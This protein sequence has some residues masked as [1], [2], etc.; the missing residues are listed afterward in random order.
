MN[1]K[2]VII[3]AAVVAL[4]A[5]ISTRHLSLTTST[6]SPLPEFSLPD[7]A[8][9]SHNI[10]EWHGKIL[11]INFWATWCPPCLKEIPEFISLQQTYA[12]KNLT[13]IGIAMD[14]REA[15]SQFIANKPVNYPILMTKEDGIA[16]TRKLGNLADAIPYT[17][18][19][20]PKG[21]IIYRHPGEL[22]KQQLLDAITPLVN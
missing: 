21:Q 8:G 3:I 13:V 7:L 5:G 16:L 1:Q 20:D 10:R 19:V 15:V 18:I 4:A 9:Q 14:D 11:V 17:I 12:E 2:V 6:Q 22:T